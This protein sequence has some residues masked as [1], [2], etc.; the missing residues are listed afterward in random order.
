MTTLKDLEK[1]VACEKEIQASLKRYNCALISIPT[2]TTKTD[3]T[4]V[5]TSVVRVEKI[6]EP[7]KTKYPN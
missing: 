6:Y 7:K 5:A 2:I 4:L 3:G 1:A